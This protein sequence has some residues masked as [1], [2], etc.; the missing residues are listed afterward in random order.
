MY[1]K[2]LAA[3]E[4]R[5]TIGD[6][7]IQNGIQAECF[8]GREEKADWCRII[9]DG[10]LEGRIAIKDMDRAELSLGYDD[11][12]D[13][14]IN[15]YICRSSED[16]W[17]EFIIKDDM[18]LLERCRIAAT[19]LQCTPQDIIRYILTSA[20]ISK[21]RI[22]NEDFG[23]LEKVTIPAGTGIGAIKA[24]NIAYAISVPCYVQNGIFY[25]GCQEE[26]KE[27]YILEEDNSII[28]LERLGSLWEAETVGIPWAH[29]GETIEVSHRSASGS[30]TVEK[31]IIKSDETGSVR[32]YIYFKGA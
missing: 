24:V 22:S 8:L 4:F 29:C 13:I 28:N 31:V 11:D 6:V 32:Q 26:Q 23:Q 16:N 19:F 12:F 25:W 17:R 14:I 30:F 27:I 15:G 1:L 5:L 2:K 3:P 20:G 18:L 9:L 10:A 7:S 21:Y